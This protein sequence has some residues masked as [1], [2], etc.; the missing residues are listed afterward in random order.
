MDHVFTL[1]EL[2]LLRAGLEEDGCTQSA[3]LGISAGA[4]GLATRQV[5]P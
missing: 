5:G 1:E 2:G 4:E 3:V